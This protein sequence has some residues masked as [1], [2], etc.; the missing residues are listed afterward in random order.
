MHTELS[1]Y[2]FVA[3]ALPNH[4]AR[5]RE[6]AQTMPAQ[7][8]SYMELPY[9]PEYTLYNKCLALSRLIRSTSRKLVNH[10]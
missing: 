6:F 1:Q 9:D 10:P 7:L 8:L 2:R 3:R 5:P 4:C